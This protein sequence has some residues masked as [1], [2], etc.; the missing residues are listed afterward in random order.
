MMP[1]TSTRPARAARSAAIVIGLCLGWLGCVTSATAADP[2]QAT[3]ATTPAAKVSPSPRPTPDETQRDTCRKYV[4]ALSGDKDQKDLLE[5]SEVQTLARQVPDLVFCGAVTADSD[6]I[7]Q[8]LAPGEKFRS[9][10]EGPANI[11]CAAWAQMHELRKYPKGRSYFFDD[12]QYQQCKALPSLASFCD[13]FR[14]ALRSGDPAQCASAGDLK[15]ICVAY[16]K[17]DKSL[18]KG[19][20]PEGAGLEKDCRKKIDKMAGLAG[21]LQ[22]LSTAGKPRDRALAKAA[23]GTPDACAALAQTATDICLNQSVAASAPAESST[24]AGETP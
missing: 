8:V 19:E 2:T 16:L 13:A 18:C 24:P 4:A 12:M 22:G 1:Y 3:A 9:L 6:D 10:T 17:V 23:L 5:E 20:G 21:G 14:D 15:S 11:C 7:C